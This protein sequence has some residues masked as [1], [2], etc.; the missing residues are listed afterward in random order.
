MKVHACPVSF[1]EARWRPRRRLF[2]CPGRFVIWPSTPAS[3]PPSSFPSPDLSKLQKL[4]L[5]IRSAPPVMNTCGGKRRTVERAAIA[6]SLARVERP[7]HLTRQALP[8]F[9]FAIAFSPGRHP[10]NPPNRW[11]PAGL[12][13][14]DDRCRQDRRPGFRLRRRL[15]T[16]HLA[17]HQDHPGRAAEEH[18][19]HIPQH[20]RPR[21]PRIAFRPDHR[22]DSSQLIAI[23]SATS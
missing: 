15:R 6:S 1:L 4:W 12:R 7:T 22:Q 14:D 11:C 18:R 19:H 23:A 13:T 3:L 5:R 2:G 16:R 10:S 20:N 17:R 21:K 9:H 8:Y